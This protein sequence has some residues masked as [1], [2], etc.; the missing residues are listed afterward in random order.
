MRPYL[1]RKPSQK[2]ACGVAQ[3]VGPEF[4]PQHCKKEKKVQIP[5]TNLR[6]NKSESLGVEFLDLYLKNQ[7]K[8][9]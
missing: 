9:L 8:K 1:K 6:H 3:G 7:K 5:R 4:K 2:R